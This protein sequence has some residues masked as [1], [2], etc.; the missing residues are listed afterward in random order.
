M[1]IIKERIIG[2][3]TVMSEDDAKKIWTMILNEVA[4]KDYS[5]FNFEEVDPDD[6]EKKILDAWATGDPD[7]QPYITHE[8]LK[9]E[10]GL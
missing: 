8:Q 2:A 1:S 6:N 3:V 5:N 9:T 7:Y 4:P 10:L